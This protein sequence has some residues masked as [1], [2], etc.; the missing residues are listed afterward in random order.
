MIFFLDR[1]GI[2][3]TPTIQSILERQIFDISNRACIF[4]EVDRKEM[5]EIYE[6]F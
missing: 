3:L 6:L 4:P 5:L 2:G 1:P